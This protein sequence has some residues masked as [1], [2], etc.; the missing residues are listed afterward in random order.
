MS[1][2]IKE[3]A[4]FIA[5]AHLNRK[6]LELIEFLNKVSSK[7][8]QTTQ[9]IL[10]GD[11][12]DFLCADAKYFIHIN[13]GVI[14]TL[15]SLSKEIEIIYLEGNHD[16]NLQ[17]L[18]PNIK[19]VPRKKQP[20]IL[21]YEDKTVAL[22]HGD[23]FIDWKY[24]LYCAVIRNKALIKFL[25]YVDI[26]YWLTKRIE[27]GL[28]SKSICHKIKEFKSLAAKR[29]ENYKTDYIVEGHYHQGITYNFKDKK[30]INIPSLCCNKMYMSLRK[31][32]FSNVYL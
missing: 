4:I 17:D 6:N 25:N 23:N 19:V 1:L 13:Q 28:L 29:S 27:E 7:K 21:K 22:A 20:L 26:D 3:G 10:M 16:Y 2:N 32:S 18:F 30:Y 11:I 14:N 12:F 5:D 15:N 24:D 8:I 9:L 31:N